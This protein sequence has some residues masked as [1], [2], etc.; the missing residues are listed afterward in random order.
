MLSIALA[1]ASAI[2]WGTGDFIGGLKTKSFAVPLVLV[3]TSLGGLLFALVMAFASGQEIPPSHDLMLGAASGVI[4]LIALGAFYKALAIGTMSIVAPVS[5]SGTAIP[6]IWGLANGETLGVLAYCGLVA[7]VIGVMIASREQDAAAEGQP[8]AINHRASIFLA[9][10]GAAGFGTIFV[11][12][13]EASS[14]SEFWPIV[15]LKGTSL[16]VI[17]LV[18]AATWSK[19]PGE[20]PTGVLILPLM[21]VGVLDVTANATYA[22]ATTEGPIAIASVVASMFPITTVILA[23]LILGE[24]IVRIQKVGVVLALLG[25][26]VL[27]GT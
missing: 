22:F 11:L 25:V 1:L 4:G 10:V 20:R 5:A 2:A 6:V 16:V 23:H 9:L 19:I 17:S 27:A 3:G 12:I 8:I 7:V 21:L 18:V 24:R 15:S 13:A 26:I 14:V